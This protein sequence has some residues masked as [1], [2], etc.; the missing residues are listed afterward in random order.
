MQHKSVENHKQD[1]FLF[2][3]ISNN[4]LRWLLFTIIKEINSSE[5][6]TVRV[7]TRRKSWDSENVFLIVSVQLKGGISYLTTFK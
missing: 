1:R 7:Q 5:N 6:Y 4:K 2:E 3:K